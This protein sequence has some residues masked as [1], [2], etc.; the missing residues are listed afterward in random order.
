MRWSMAASGLA[1]F[2]ALGWGT[3][4]SASSQ[5]DLTEASL[6]R[7]KGTG[8]SASTTTTSGTMASSSTGIPG[9][10]GAPQDILSPSTIK[11]FVNNDCGVF[12]RA[13]AVDATGTGTQ[14][15][16]FKTLQAALE[17][18]D[19]KA[20]FVCASAPFA[21]KVDVTRALAMYGGFDCTTTVD[22]SWSD[23]A[24]S[25]IT[26]AADEIPFTI[27][28]AASNV[29]IWNV[30]ITAAD[31]TKDS[32]SSIALAIADKV[33][34]ALERCD[35]TAGAG[36]DGLAG[37]AYSNKAAP[38]ANASTNVANACIPPFAALP[39]KTT[40]N[41]ITTDGGPGGLGGDPANDSGNGQTG[42]E[43]AP[44]GGTG[45]A[46][47]GD[48][49]AGAPTACTNGGPGTPGGAG[50]TG[51]AGLSSSTTLSLTGV[52][53]GSGGD[54]KPGVPGQ[55]GG[56][57]GGTRAGAFCGGGMTT[58]GFGPGGGGGGAGGC[59]GLGG[60]GGQI[61]GSSIAIL[62]LGTQV[63]LTDVALTTG[64]GG[65][66]GSGGSAQ[67]GGDP[68]SAGI[69]GNKAVAG[70]NNGCDGGKGGKG[71]AGGKGGG[72]RGGHSLGLA[73]AVTPMATPTATFKGG[74]GGAGGDVGNNGA[75]A[76]CWDF[77]T[78]AACK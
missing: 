44:I 40:C 27:E 42:G 16:P 32:G 72:G 31:A 30:A 77:S 73:F 49:K 76:V 74:A 6:G 25:T 37:M 18:A 23:A 66:G 63:T 78:N 45:K 2:G 68:G 48:G 26:G 71:G 5:E 20:V 29:T 8:G 39:G 10:L 14:E 12:V 65:K 69:G 60:G 9:C 33:V 35:I 7:A 67:L 21:E 55:G 28:A 13:D 58:V 15:A 47:L 3:G 70:F 53:G 17:T 24:R 56:G 4:C 51:A 46:G 38:G 43:G 62:S 50:G 59:G 41:G 54:G 36:K 22:W 11:H 57:G 64:A 61:G 1:V 19:G 75:A 34:T 52:G